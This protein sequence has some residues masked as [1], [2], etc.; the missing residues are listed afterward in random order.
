MM[1]LAPGRKSLLEECIFPAAAA[2]DAPPQV[3]ADITDDGLLEKPLPA[4]P[5]HFKI[6]GGARE[7]EETR[8]PSGPKEDWVFLLVSM[9]LRR[10]TRNALGLL[11]FSSPSK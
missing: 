2:D 11:L 3:E 5:T 10:S 1:I 4:R 8:R 7:P 6:G 9:V